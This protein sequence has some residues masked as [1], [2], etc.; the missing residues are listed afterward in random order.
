[1]EQLTV[2]EL[3]VR[4]GLPGSTI[5]MYQTKG[6][7]HPPRRQGR[8]AYYDGS[9]LERLTLVQRLQSRGF[10]LPAI[11]ELVKA[12]EQGASVAAVLG[13]GEAE[14]PDDW[15]RIKVRDISRLVPIGDVRPSVLRRAIQLGLVRWRRGWPHVR[16]WA[17]D[18]GNRLTALNVPSDDVLDKFANLRTATDAIAAD[19]V[20]VFERRLWPQLADNAQLADTDT[21]GQD[22]QLDRMRALLV[23]LTYTAETVVIGTLRESVREAAEQFARRHQLLPN[24]DFRP[25]WVEEPVPIAE[26]LIQTDEDDEIPDEPTIQRFLDRGD[27]QDEPLR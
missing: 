24:D 10:S 26:R 15:V 27:D 16:R 20:E 13:V 8:V 6:V 9:H 25:A 3:A 19:F 1:M 18:A 17:L 22:D 2:D 14:G 23:E 7:L 12:R 4:V 5:R 21:P 11:A